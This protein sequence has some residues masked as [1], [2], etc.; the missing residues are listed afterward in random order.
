MFAKHLALDTDLVTLEKFGMT[1]AA[2]MQRMAIAI[3]ISIRVTADRAE[4]DVKAVS[5]YW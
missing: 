1:I 5:W 4:G 3:T 2:R